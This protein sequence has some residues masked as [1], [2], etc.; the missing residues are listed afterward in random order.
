MR[1]SGR[2]R[3]AQVNAKQEFELHKIDY[4]NG[5]ARLN[6]GPETQSSNLWPPR[7]ISIGEAQTKTGKY[8]HKNLE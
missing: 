7:T 2:C 3:V 6:D 1:I 4:K 8:N 5:D